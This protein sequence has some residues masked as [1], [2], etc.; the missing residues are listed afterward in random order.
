M[1]PVSIIIPC[2]N[3]GTF[4]AEAIDSALAQTY[5]QTE[6]LVMDDGSH[7][8]TPEVAKTYG[9]RIRYVRT[10]N[11]GHGATLNDALTR[12]QG[13]YFVC[14][15][16]DNTLLPEYVAK[17][18]AVLDA[19]DGQT[20]FVY[21]QRAF[22]G[23][24]TGVSSAPPYDLKRLKARNFIDTCTLIRTELGRRC[25]Y[26]EHLIQ[27]DYDFYLTVAEHGYGGVLLDEV[28]YRYRV[29]PSSMSRAITSRYR[30]LEVL[31]PVLAKHAHFFSGEERGIALR[32]ARYRHLLAVIHNRHPDHQLKVRL[33]DLA[34]II[35]GRASAVQVW[36]QLRYTVSPR[37][38]T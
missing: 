31:A 6:V 2:F 32:E 26:D 34:A 15:D 27:A 18:V 21:T 37:V 7:D 22:F 11:R 36:N 5:P 10:P 4:L 30:H 24:V 16:A 13:R 17:T 19:A 25:R 14:L 9:D 28:L 38:F 3:Y 29:H 33:A 1:N 20:G 8:H 12:I 23:Q 35:R